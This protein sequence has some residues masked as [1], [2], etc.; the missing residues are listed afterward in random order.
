MNRRDFLKAAGTGLASFAAIPAAGQVAGQRPILAGDRVYAAGN[1]AIELDGINAGWVYNAEGGHAA[2]DVVLERMSADRIIRKH[3][4]NVKYEE[5]TVQCGTGMSKAFYQWIQDSFNR[6]YS[7][8]NGAI[9][10]ATYD[11]KEVSRLTFN[12]AL[13]S[14]IGFPALDVASKDAARMTVKLSPEV[15][16]MMLS[17][18]GGGSVVGKAP[19]SAAI[20]KRW[21]PANFRLKIDGLEAPCSR[22][23]KIE[24][25][26]IK[27][28]NTTN[29]AG[30]EARF[31]QKEA[32]F[33]EFPNLVIT[34]PVSHAA[35]FYKW[36]EDFVIKGNNSADRERG[37]T[38]EYLTPDLGTSLFTLTFKNLGIFKC[39]PEKVEAGSENIRRVKAEMYCEEIGFEYKDV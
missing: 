33:L 8:K 39:A 32:A 11:S 1:Y 16:K 35:D 10:A 38:L 25:L 4:A 21:L 6:K 22:V 5:I 3:I 20:Q 12:N 34:F 14:E 36:H 2:S 29:T 9:I 27:Q 23:N 13:I 31:S 17:S 19:T 24:A 37:G 15:T 30:A 18:G 28:K 26:A 7:R